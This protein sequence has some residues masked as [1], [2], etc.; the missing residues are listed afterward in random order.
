MSDLNDFSYFLLKVAP[1]L[2]TKFRI[3]WPFG[4]GEEA[5]N[6]FSRWRPSWITDRSDF[7]YF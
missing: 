2:P 5:Q 6:I 1:I 4:S 7:S 3:N